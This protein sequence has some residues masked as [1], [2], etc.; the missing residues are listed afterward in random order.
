MVENLL[1]RVASDI[2]ALAIPHTHLHLTDR[3]KQ[4]QSPHRI[5]YLRT[6]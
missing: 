6:F 4:P 5:H 2:G 3:D 1:G